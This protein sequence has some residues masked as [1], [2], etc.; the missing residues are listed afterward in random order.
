M[1]RHVL[2]VNPSAVHG[3]AE[4]VLLRMMGY[5]RE[6]E[7]Q[8]VLVVPR[9]GWLTEQ[10]EAQ[11]IAYEFLPTLPDAFTSDH[12]QQQFRPWPRN[13]LAIARLA[14][15]WGAAIVHSNTPRASYHGGLGARLARVA[16]V[17]HVHDIVS[18]PYASP[19]KAR[20]LGSLTDRTLVV[21]KAVERAVLGFAPRLEARVQ[22]LYNGWDVSVYEGVRPANLRELFGVPE[23]AFVI[24]N[25]SALTPWK[26]QDLL[27]TAFRELHERHPEAHLLVVGG[28]Q[29][30]ERQSDYERHLRQL[31]AALGLEGA[32]TLTGWRE[33]AWALIKSFDLFVHVP[34]EP[35]PLPTAL[36]H[37]CA[38]GRACIGAEI[39][40]VPEILDG[41]AA[42]VLVPPRDAPALAEAMH[43]L[44]EDAQRR[45]ALGI[46]A[47]EHFARRFSRRQMA[48]GLD[49]AYRQC[50]S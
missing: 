7:Y 27:V 33:D 3:G 6:Y 26:G 46:R 13:A 19:L 25:V 37:A 31:V 15:K 47:R 29:G 50:L 34:T 36:L 16:A 32:V 43:S 48:A 4:E 10:C 38:L 45:Q 30:S 8:P 28:A 1:S 35:D 22:T 5:A 20:L 12:W 2:Y 24:G 41:G 44:M 14:R 40:G 17:T 49:Y 23:D 39:G 42:G 11:G 18:L 21:S 9:G